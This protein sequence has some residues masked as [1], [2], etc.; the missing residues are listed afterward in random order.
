MVALGGGGVEGALQ[1]DAEGH[2]PRGVWWVLVAVRGGVGVEGAGVVGGGGGGV[3]GFEEAECL[4]D[5]GI[6]NVVG[7]DEVLQSLECR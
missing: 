6:P 1:G 4:G 3:L 5:E 7:V 2:G